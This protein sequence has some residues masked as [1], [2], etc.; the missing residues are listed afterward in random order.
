MGSYLLIDYI[1]LREDCVEENIDETE[2]TTRYKQMYEDDETLYNEKE[3]IIINELYE[4]IT[5]EQLI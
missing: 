2:F 3:K 5:G 1:M 4:E